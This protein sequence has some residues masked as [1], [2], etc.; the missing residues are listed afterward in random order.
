M[1]AQLGEEQAAA[2]RRALPAELG[3]DWFIGFAVDPSR[4]S[5][6]FTRLDDAAAE[7]AARLVGAEAK[8]GPVSQRQPSRARRK[9]VAR[10]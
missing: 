5:A 1:L 9:R 10:K 4:A 8:L 3:S 2:L 7:A 6:A